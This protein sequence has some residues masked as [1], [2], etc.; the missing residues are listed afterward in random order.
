MIGPLKDKIIGLYRNSEEFEE[1][2]IKLANVLLNTLEGLQVEKGVQEFLQDLS[3]QEEDPWWDTVA[4]I[5]ISPR[6]FI[7]TNKGYF[8]LAPP[9]VQQGDF[10]SL[11]SGYENPVYLRRMG[12]HYILTGVGWVHGLIDEYYKQGW[13]EGDIVTLK[14]K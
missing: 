12:D 10:L 3:N 14:I 5:L 7:K 8:G 9:G 11:I 6:Q 13:K 2:V 4:L 1:D